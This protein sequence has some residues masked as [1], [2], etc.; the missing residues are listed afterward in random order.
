[1]LLRDSLLFPDCFVV[2]NCL[3]PCSCCHRGATTAPR[4][5]ENQRRGRRPEGR[6]YRRHVS[7]VG[8]TRV[9]RGRHIG[10]LHAAQIV[11]CPRR[12]GTLCCSPR[13]VADEGRRYSAPRNLPRPTPVGLAC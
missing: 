2:R 8:A 12:A 10:L 11:P 6:L 1:M 3:P 5:V 9:P 7:A 13:P 4:L